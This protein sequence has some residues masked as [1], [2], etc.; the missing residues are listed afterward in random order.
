MQKRLSNDIAGLRFVHAFGWLRAAE[1]GALLYPKTTTATIAAARIIRSWEQ[2]RFVIVRE[3][4]ERAGRAVV[5]AA[6]GVRFLSENGHHARSGKD[7]GNT[8]A[9]AWKPPASWRHDL[10]AAGVLAA[11]RKQ[12]YGVVPE[13]DLRRKAS[14]C[15]KLPDGILKSPSG[16]RIWLEVEHSRKTG[17][18]LRELG[19]ALALAAAG[20]IKAIAG[21]RCTAA[22]FAYCVTTDERGYQINHRERVLKAISEYA[23]EPLEVLIARCTMVGVGVNSVELE[24]TLVEPGKW[25]SVRR[26][27]DSNGWVEENGALQSHYGRHQVRIWQANGRWAYQLEGSFITY[28]ETISDAKQQAAQEFAEQL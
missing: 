6:A 26:V 18:S 23:Q 3:L 17:R 7:L 4:P 11:L 25:L 15:P 14:D 21:T 10:I 5:L 27:L 20:E 16:Q 8:T 13:T 1:L 24:K 19:R 9:G 28:C 12:G 22:M 2:R